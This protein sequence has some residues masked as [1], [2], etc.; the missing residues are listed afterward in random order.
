VRPHLIGID[1]GPFEKDT[2]PVTPIVGVVMEG[3]D[4][5]EGVAITSFPIDGAGV[6]DFLAEWIQGLRFRPGLQGIVLGGITI[7][8]LAVIDVERLS[9][10]LDLPVLVL[11]R[12]D[13]RNHRLASALGSAGLADRLE[14]VDRTP[15]SLALRCGLYLACAGTTPEEAVALIDATR[16]KGEM[17][18][19]FRLAHLIA[20][21]VVRGESRGR[22]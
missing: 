20:S 16:R 19:P 18:E 17:P 5:V 1:D 7:A 22:V 12:K 3:S 21:A 10:A 6:T 15:P 11:N 2:D 9:E 4:L 13:P 8:G 14:V